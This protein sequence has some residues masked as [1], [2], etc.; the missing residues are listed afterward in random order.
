M[1][2]DGPSAQRLADELP[3]CSPFSKM[4]TP[5]P[6]APSISSSKRAMTVAPVELSRA[7]SCRLPIA[8]HLSMNR[9]DGALCS[10]SS[11]T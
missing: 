11:R 10:A 4:M 2:R 8:S 1:L 5:G 3:A 6:A 9:I 7:L